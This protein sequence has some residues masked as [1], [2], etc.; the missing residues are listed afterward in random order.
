MGLKNLRKN[1]SRLLKAFG[2]AGV[3]LTESQKGD[4][5]Q[6]MLALES[7]IDN[8]KMAAIRATKKVV[9]ENLDKKYREVFESV[10]KHQAECLK[11][12][13]KI[14]ARAAVI[15]ERKAMSERL[16]GFLDECL[17]ESMPKQTVV[18]MKRLESLEALRGQLCEALALSDESVAAK[19][20]ELEDGFKAESEKLQKQIDESKA[21]LDKQ[22]GRNVDLKKRLEK[23]EARELLESKIKDLPL[24]EANQLRRRF[25]GAT[26]SLI[27]SKFEKALAAVKEEVEDEV[28][29]EETSLE[30]EIANIVGSDEKALESEE[31]NN[32]EGSASVDESDDEAEDAESEDEETEDEEGDEATSDAGDDSEDD[33]SETIGESYMKQWIARANSIV[34]LR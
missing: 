13:G 12:A 27:E 30:E 24:F 20:K 34:P 22:I 25:E 8:T 15:A 3:V 4:I 17:E 33:E 21:E 29:D 7:T 5:D 28:S 26:K 9:S 19:K 10:M 23:A 32:D 11:L 31:E 16:D 6:F 2:Q 18:D 14:E 1:Y